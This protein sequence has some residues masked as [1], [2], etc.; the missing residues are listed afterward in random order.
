[1]TAWLRFVA[2]ALLPVA[3]S[4]VFVLLDKFTKFKNLNYWVKQVIFGV[5]FGLLAIYGTERGVPMKGVVMN[6]RDAAPLCAGLLFGSPAGIIAG[7]IGGIERFIRAP[8]VGEYTKYACT[9]ATIFAG[10]LAAWARKYLFEDEKPLWYHGLFL[11]MIAEVVHMLMVFIMGMS[12]ARRGFEIVRACAVPMIIFNACSVALAIVAVSLLK[13]ERM[14]VPR[15]QQSISRSF[16]FWLLI[17]VVIAFVFTS[18]FTAALQSQVA[19]NETFNLLELNLADVEM[20][21][22]QESDK[23]ILDLTKVVAKEIEAMDG[24]TS[25]VK[26]EALAHKYS[27]SEINIVDNT[28]IIRATTEKANAGFNMGSGKQSSEFMQ[29]LV[30]S[31]DTYVQEYQAITRDS[32][33]WYKYAGAKLHGGGFVQVGYDSQ[34]FHDDIVESVISLAC[35]RHI[36]E[37]GYI[38]I[39]NENFEI[40]TGRG[41]EGENLL[42]AGMYIDRKTMPE[43]TVFISEMYG[44]EASCMYSIK[45]GY[46]IIAVRPQREVM[47]ARDI[48]IY[49]TTFMEVIIFAILFFMI[50]FLVDKYIVNNIHN[51][52][53]T[54]S[55]ITDG[56]LDVPVDV[57]ASKEFATLSDHISSTVV[58]LKRYIA[59]AE[60]RIDKEL[61]FAKTIQASALPKVPSNHPEF[62]AW[63]SMTPAK[64]VGGDFYDV[65]MLYNNK[66]AFTIADVSGKGIPAAMFMMKAKAM[67]KNLAKSGLEVDEVFKRANSELC[68]GNEAEMFV[69]A[70]MGIIDLDTGLVTFANAGHN[71]PLVRHGDG[72]FEYLKSRAGFVL[73]GM[74]G[75]KYRKNELQLEEGDSIFLY[76]DGVTEATNASNELYGEERL[77]AMLDSVAH[78]DSQ[79]ICK[80]V[81]Q[82]VDMFVGEAPQF[83]DI[84]MF[85]LKYKEK[86]GGNSKVNEMTVSATIENIETVTEFV[87]KQLEEAG[88]SSKAEIQINVAIDEL[89]SNIAHYAYH[90]ET[91]DATVRVEVCEEPLSVIITFI[92]NGMPYDPLQNEDPDISLSA[93]ERKVGGLGI[94]MVKKTMDEVTYEYKDG[95]NIL[96]IKK[97]I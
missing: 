46:Y 8:W 37:T 56:D 30:S 26:L 91:G 57:R 25:T 80:R 62:N 75:I 48:A 47:Y 1:M 78:L 33:I 69:T 97:S 29:L 15:E 27:I 34:H 96:T 76:T 70:W 36:G 39:C 92:D 51:V 14:Y 19:E 52:N 77:S 82:N 86:S 66:M 67:L 63:A 49:I 32:H 59:E 72:S 41:N 20:D 35:N 60:A 42:K 6:V 87:D 88:C 21:I 7:L 24:D 3:A 12:E 68:E 18:I 73:G 58:T 79:T 10:V 2:A 53:N 31:S 95:K 38:V 45:E 64:E 5:V 17:C 28:G 61:E 16:Q 13:K 84:T 44:E 40:I 85:C 43:K 81:K 50:Y 23:N 55:K 94:F 83:D 65:Y 22:T 4:A 11:G 90:P 54:L 93:D 71:P 89:F 74:D 9:F